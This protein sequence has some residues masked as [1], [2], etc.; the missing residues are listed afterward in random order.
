MQGGPGDSA[1]GWEAK[2]MEPEGRVGSGSPGISPGPCTELC[3]ERA[4]E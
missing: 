3:T 2:D 1:P 4:G